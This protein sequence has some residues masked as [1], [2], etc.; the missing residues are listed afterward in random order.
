MGGIK[1]NYS[2]NLPVLT[3]V[4]SSHSYVYVLFQNLKT[5]SALEIVRVAIEIFHVV[6]GIN[7]GSLID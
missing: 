7:S 4:N 1:Y 6:L 5:L 3:P 2:Q